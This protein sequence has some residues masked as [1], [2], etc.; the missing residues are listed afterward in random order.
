MAASV[1]LGC[2]SA[3]RMLKADLVAWLLGL[4]LDSCWLILH[5]PCFFTQGSRQNTQF[6]CYCVEIFFL[7]VLKN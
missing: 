5:E 3:I 1:E 4:F 6:K 2:G 7:N